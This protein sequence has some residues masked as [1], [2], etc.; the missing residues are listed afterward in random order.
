[1]LQQLRLFLTAVQFFTRLPV[2]AWVGHS[3]QQLDQSARYFP[4][5]GL[6]V[7]GLSA[8]VFWLSSCVVP[9]T[10]AVALSMLASILLTGAFHEDGLSDFVDGMGGGYSRVKILAIMKDSH[11]GAYGVIAI[12]LALLFKFQALLA[13]S[14]RHS[15][16]VVAATLLAAH[17]ISRLLA[18]SI[19]LTQHYVR[20]D[21]TAR[22]KPVA[23]TL[24][25]ASF[26]IAALTGVAALVLLF[27][28]GGNV[29][30]IAAALAC[31]LLLR[32]YLGWQMHKKLGGYTG[33]CLGAV[34]QITEIGFYLGMLLSWPS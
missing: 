4:L 22:A 2:P 19:M 1:M 13:L 8:S 26:S 23:Q 10:L 17:G 11:A 18:V 9:I 6:C 34:Q 5:V 16:V 27:V 28:A 3:A 29:R 33:D 31:A 21:A 32:I 14:G 12:V 24:S 7:G 25:R 30:N 15:L 20:E